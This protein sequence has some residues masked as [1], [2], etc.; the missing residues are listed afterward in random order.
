MSKNTVY[1]NKLIYKQWRFDGLTGRSVRIIRFFFTTTFVNRSYCSY[2]I[3]HT[4]LYVPV[5]HTD[6]CR[7]SSKR[8]DQTRRTHDGRT[9]RAIFLARQVGGS[10]PNEGVVNWQLGRPAC[11][12]RT[13]GLGIG[14]VLSYTACMWPDLPHRASAA[15]NEGAVSQLYFLVPITTRAAAFT[16]RCRPNLSV[17]NSRLQ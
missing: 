10:W 14:C 4:V 2:D 12:P 6:H 11:K 5:D 7:V 13:G 1:N 3:G 9:Y 15:Q 17:A 8:S 16:T